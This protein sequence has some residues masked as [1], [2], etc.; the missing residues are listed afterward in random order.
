VNLGLS[1]PGRV[2]KQK[3]HSDDNCALMNA[4]P[5]TV[6]PLEKILPRHRTSQ[7]P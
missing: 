6:H 3:Y 5:A 1:P 4:L 7:P 2:L